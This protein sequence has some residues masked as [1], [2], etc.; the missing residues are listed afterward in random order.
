MSPDT[1]QDSLGAIFFSICVNDVKPEE[2]VRR[3]S[4]T[5]TGIGRPARPNS[6]CL[7]LQNSGITGV[8]NQLKLKA[9]DSLP[10]WFTI[11]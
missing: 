8:Y 3:D 7:C 1:A 11:M 2:V 9:R 10:S 5:E 4:L 6:P